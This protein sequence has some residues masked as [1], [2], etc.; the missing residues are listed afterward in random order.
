MGQPS[1][2]ELSRM[3]AD[4][5]APAL[6][7]RGFYEIGNVLENE[8]L[9]GQDRT[10]FYRVAQTSVV[11]VNVWVTDLDPPALAAD[12]T[13]HSIPAPA[14]NAEAAAYANDDVADLNMQVS[15]V[16]DLP[17]TV[18]HDAMPGGWFVFALASQ[19]LF[20]LWAVIA[21]LMTAFKNKSNRRPSA[22]THRFMNEIPKI[23]D[24]LRSAA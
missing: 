21:P 12:C 19:F 7:A 5:I 4:H 9:L 8:H 6:H 10:F 16:I 18:T 15:R 11:R 3:M 22:L 14:N 20:I 13:T 24:Y 2:I 23:D 1:R 17:L